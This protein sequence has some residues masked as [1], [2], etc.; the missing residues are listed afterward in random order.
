MP[1]DADRVRRRW[2]G[3]ALTALSLAAGACSGIPEVVAVVDGTPIAGE[4]LEVLHTDAGGLEPEERASSVYLL[5]LHQ[6]LVAGAERDF[7]VVVDQEAI[8]EAFADRTKRYGD[9]IDDG[10]Q[11]R[12]VT[13]ARVMLE[14]ELDVIRTR[15]VA[16]LIARGNAFDLDAAYRQFISTNSIACL[17]MLAPTGP[18]VESEIAALV[19]SD[20][21]L[22]QVEATLPEAV[23]RVDLGCTNPFQHPAPVQPVAVDGEIGRA[24]LRS[25]SDGTVYVVAVTERDAPPIEDVMEEV[26]ILAAETQGPDL[27]NSWAVGMLREAEVEIDAS[28]GAWQ[29]TPD[30]NDIPTVVATGS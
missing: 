11:Q 6:L 23:E 7:A 28:I 18:E 26:L 22:E 9:E 5:V 24:Y 3:A 19:E 17:S 13:R 21:T 2:F 16:E 8:D 29:P 25:F 20:V 4:R 1:A 12:G 15:V 10:L 14:A 27:F 30:S